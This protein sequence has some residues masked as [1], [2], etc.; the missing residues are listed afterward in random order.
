MKFTTAFALVA[1]TATASVDGK[2]YWGPGKHYLSKWCGH[3]G[4]KTQWA[5]V[6][7]D[8]KADIICDDTAGRHWIRLQT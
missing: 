8:G 3:K 4:A 1:A 6:N 7:G 5:D 2:F